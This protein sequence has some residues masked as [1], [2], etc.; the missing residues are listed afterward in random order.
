MKS[1]AM[2][3]AR[4]SGRSANVIEYGLKVL[5]YNLVSC[6]V[7]LAAG[8]ALRILP[9]VAAAYIAG[10][11]LRLASGGVHTATPERCALVTAGMWA[12]AGFLGHVL[13]PRMAGPVLWAAAGGVL[14]GVLYLLWRFAPRDVPQKPIKAERR[15]ILRAW[16]FGIW[17]FWAAAVG[18]AC[19]AGALAGVVPAVLLGLVLQSL[20]LVPD[21]KTER[22]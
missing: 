5:V 20:S 4:E 19:A 17:A 1:V 11:S 16:A 10:G 7:V 13:G 15:R 21:T 8:W 22:R 3:L 12:A 14:L 9:E 2:E 18:W 6:L